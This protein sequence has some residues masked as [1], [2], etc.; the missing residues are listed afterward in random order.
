MSSIDYGQMRAIEELQERLNQEILAHR[1]TK[2]QLENTASKRIEIYMNNTEKRLESQIEDLKKKNEELMRD[3]IILNGK[4]SM[5]QEIIDQLE[6]DKKIFH[7]R[8]MNED[9]KISALF[10]L[11]TD[12]KNL[13]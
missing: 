1:H 8:M 4:V 13:A 9:E 10:K 2:A 6:N 11:V 5:F 3:K 7:D 12:Q